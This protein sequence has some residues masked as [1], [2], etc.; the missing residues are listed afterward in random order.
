MP[1]FIEL[2]P[3]L[4]DPKLVGA[5]ASHLRR[6]WAR[7]AAFDALR[8]AFEH[9]ATSDATTGW[10]I[11][12]AL[13]TAATKDDLPVLVGIVRATSYRTARQMIVHS[14]WRFKAAPEVESTLV[15]LLDDPD[16]ALHAMSALRRTVGPTSALPHLRR[17]AAEHTGDPIGST[18]LR[19]IRKAEATVR[20]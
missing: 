7:P 2:L 1:V 11:G 18:A 19:Q 4:S 6:P 5:I 8:T 16:V 20:T 12:D 3:R 9:W 15:S 13:A 10:H 17:V 14:L